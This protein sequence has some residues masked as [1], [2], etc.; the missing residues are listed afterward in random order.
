[1]G[2]NISYSITVVNNGPGAASGI[3]LTITLPAAVD[4]VSATPE[5]GAGTCGLAVT[6]NC[7]LNDLNS[8]EDWLITLVVDT[9]AKGRVNVTANVTGDETDTDLRDNEGTAATDA[10]LSNLVVKSL[11]APKAALPDSDITINDVTANL[12]RIPA[13]VSTTRFYLSPD[14]RP[15]H[16]GEELALG[17]NRG[18]SIIALGPKQS[19]AGATQVKIPPATAL[20]RYFLI[21]VA[22]ADNSNVETRENNKKLRALLV[23]RPD[24]KI[25][26]LRAPGKV[27]AGGT[28]TITDTTINNSPLDAAQSTT[29][30]F[31]STD[32]VKDGGDTALT[33]NGRTVPALAAKD[34]HTDSTSATIPGGTAPGTYFLIAVADADNAVT[35]A[36]ET[37]NTRARKL[38]V[39]P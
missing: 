6:V 33:V 35:E 21:A 11:I 26:A 29:R 13:D 15:D 18:R 25:S 2:D 3:E 12:G 30:F 19:S 7:S 32:A 17:V 22:D 37:D 39:T 28:L 36:D 5:P 8:G 38:L 14:R 1:V 20:G 10:T 27:A 9:T 31:L 4:F 16:P 34:K 23:T 24:L